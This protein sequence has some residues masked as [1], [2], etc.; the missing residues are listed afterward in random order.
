MGEAEVRSLFTDT[1]H[2]QCLSEI[3]ATRRCL[4]IA[5]GDERRV[6]ERGVDIK[7]SGREKPAKQSEKKQ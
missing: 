6:Q 1:F 5:R 4:M 7:K 2:L 3:A